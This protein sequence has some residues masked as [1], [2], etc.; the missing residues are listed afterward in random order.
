MESDRS[1]DWSDC[2]ACG[3]QDDRRWRTT[4]AP[5]KGGP[6]PQRSNPCPRAGAPPQRVSH[7]DH[8]VRQT[9]YADV[10]LSASPLIQIKTQTPQLALVVSVGAVHGQGLLIKKH[11]EEASRDHSLTLG[12]EFSLAHPRFTG[13]PLR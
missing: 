3:L 13:Q 8:E 5:L 1:R 12:P 11:P 10:R 6:S 7:N 9:D 2:R 4:D